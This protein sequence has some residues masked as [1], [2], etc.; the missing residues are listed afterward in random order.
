MIMLYSVQ[1][2]ICAPHLFALPHPHSLS[3]FS[4]A[5]AKKAEGWRLEQTFGVENYYNTSPYSFSF[6]HD[7]LFIYNSLLYDSTIKIGSKIDTW[8]IM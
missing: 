8:V 6:S 7:I 2:Y 5:A 4:Q 1:Y 3:L